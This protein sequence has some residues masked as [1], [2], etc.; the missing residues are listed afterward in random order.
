M[1]HKSINR[2]ELADGS[3]IAVI[4]GGPAGSFFTYYALQ[5]AER[6]GINIS[7]D[8]Y[9]AKD[10]GKIG[11]SGCNHCGGIVSESLVQKLSVDGILIPKEVIQRSINSYTLHIEQGKAII[12]TP[13]QEH[14]IAS[15]FRGC[16]P[17]G[18]TRQ[19]ERS[20]DNY[21]LSLCEK[22]GANI[23]RQKVSELEREERGILVKSKKDT[24]EYDFVV[25]GVGLGKKSLILLFLHLLAH[26]LG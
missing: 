3:N 22:K 8:I 12:Q 23:I 17:R 20:F 26:S 1:K 14:R 7:I 5:F 13:S 9:E 2:I 10:F 24:K 16:G 6:L 18:C 21:L 4:G 11:S 19:P 25:G 15:V